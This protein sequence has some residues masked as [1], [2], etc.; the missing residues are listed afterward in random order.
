[1]HTQ[2]QIVNQETF[3]HPSTWQ[4]LAFLYSRAGTTLRCAALRGSTQSIFRS[5]ACYVAEAHQTGAVSAFPHA[6]LG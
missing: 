2:L 4:V 1:M 6:L 3:N 5:H